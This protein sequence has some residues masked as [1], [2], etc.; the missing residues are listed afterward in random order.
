MRYLL[1][2]LFIITL[3]LTESCTNTKKVLY[4]NNT[5]DL[6]FLQQAEYLEPVIQKND[7]LSISVS[8]LNPDASLVFN[9]P[10]VTSTQTST[11]TGTVT[12]TS[13]YLVDQDGYIQF[14]FLGNVKAAGTTKKS[15][16]ENIT[17]AIVSKKLLLN[18]IVQV[19]YLNYRVSV[20]GEVAHPS[21][22]TIPNEKVSLLEA[23]ALAGDLT[24]YAKRDY[25]WLIREEDGKKTVKRLNLTTNDLF[26]SPYY[27]LKS[28]DVIYVEPNK[29]RVANA[30]TANQRIPVILSGLSLAIIVLDRLLR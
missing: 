20:L 27:Y 3:F 4:F 13:G 6:E 11:A 16:K 23:L 1:P 29:A 8:S 2:L 30:S 14:P 15:L 22:F 21:V 9:A 10:N 7:I 18:P 19:R 26:T 12:Q 24:I 28:N 5:K 25:V 17:A